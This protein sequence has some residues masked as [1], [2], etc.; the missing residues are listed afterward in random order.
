MFGWVFDWFGLGG[1]VLLDL[2]VLACLVIFGCWFCVIWV[3]FG[4]WLLLMLV[5]CFCD[6]LFS[7][8]CDGLWLGVLWVLCV[9][10]W[11]FYFLILLF[12]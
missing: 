1:C 8:F 10:G 5:D 4:G 6:W 7:G 12:W 3:G 2:V 11:W 9:V